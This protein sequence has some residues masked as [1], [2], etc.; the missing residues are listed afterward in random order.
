MTAATEQ[1]IFKKLDDI[2][3]KVAALNTT[4]SSFMAADAVKSK[5]HDKAAD[6]VFGNGTMGLNNKMRI[7]WGCLGVIGVAVCSLVLNWVMSHF[8]H[9]S[10]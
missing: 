8:S 10:C 3:M 5:R 4:V 1:A 2:N 7:M 9:V 6:S